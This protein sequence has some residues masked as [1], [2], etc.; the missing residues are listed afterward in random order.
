MQ[1]LE[2]VVIICQMLQSL[3]HLSGP[4]LVLLQRVYVSFTG[5]HRTR[6]SSA[7]VASLVLRITSLNLLAAL[8]WDQGEN[9]YALTLIPRAVYSCLICSRSPLAVGA[10]VKEQ[11][12]VIVWRPKRHQWFF[13]DVPC[14]PQI[15]LDSRW[16]WQ[17]EASVL[18]QQIV[19]HYT[20]WSCVVWAWPVLMLCWT[21]FPAPLLLPEH[22]TYL[23][24]ADQQVKRDLP[25]GARG[26]KLPAFTILEVSISQPD[27]YR[28][29]LLLL[30]C[31]SF[32]HYSSIS[33]N[34]RLWPLQRWDM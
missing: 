7:G 17:M 15:S 1:C 32:L 14:K 25:P 24:V 6:H 12:R 10:C 31:V 3:N 22:W 34:W 29:C 13:H 9:T 2:A 30:Q 23:V 8:W 27:K 28:S 18:P 20:W 11:H 21:N 26:H 19:S 33:R 4:L 5:E 16:G